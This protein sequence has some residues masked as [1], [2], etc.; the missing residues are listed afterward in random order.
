M[1]YPVSYSEEYYY[2]G[3]ISFCDDTGCA[4]F[5]DFLIHNNDPDSKDLFDRKYDMDGN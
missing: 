2:S 1:V 4:D 5:P 3:T